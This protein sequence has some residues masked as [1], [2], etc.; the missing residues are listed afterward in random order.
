MSDAISVVLAVAQRS[1]MMHRER[2]LVSSLWLGLGENSLQ[3]S[4]SVYGDRKQN[5]KQH[6]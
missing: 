6:L 3:R 2:M 4:G 5:W 1:S